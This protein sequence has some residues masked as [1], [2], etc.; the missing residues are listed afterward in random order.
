[1]KLAEALNE[2]ADLQKRYAQVRTRLN[3][4]ARVQEGEA[5]P[6]DPEVLLQELNRIARN[7]EQLIQRINRTNSQTILRDGMTI[8][9]A[10]VVR[11]IFRMRADAYRG[12]AEAAIVQTNRYSRTEIRTISTVNPAEMQRQADDLSRQYR[13]L[14]VAIQA[15]NWSTDLVE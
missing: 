5:P 9:D 4:S 13:E 10:I 7:L 6:E 8:S 12:L 11:D 1:M 14:D 3:Q 2:R 15:L